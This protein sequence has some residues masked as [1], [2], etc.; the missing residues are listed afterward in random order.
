MHT[1][2]VGL[3]AGAAGLW[4]AAGTASVLGADF[5][6]VNTLPTGFGSLTQAILDANDNP[7][8]DRIVF[9]VPGS[10]V[11]TIRPPT[12]GLPAITEALEIDGFS[13]PGTRPNSL[14][15]GFDG[16]LLIQIDAAGAGTGATG[17]N[18][19]GEGFSVVRGLIIT[20][21]STG[22]LI[23]SPNNVVAGN[24][25]GVAPDGVTLVGNGSGI[26]TGR[27]SGSR[28]GGASPP[29][30]N[31]IVSGGGNVILVSSVQTNLTIVGNYLGTDATGLAPL[32]RNAVSSTLSVH[33]SYGLTLGGL[34][35]GEGN[36]I[37][38]GFYGLHLYDVVGA[39]ILGNFIG[40]GADGKTSIRSTNGVTGINAVSGTRLEGNTIACCSV[41]VAVEGTGV[42]I[43]GN[44]IYANGNFGISQTGSQPINDPGDADG[45]PNELQ[46][47]P[48]L[49]ATLLEDGV[50][51]V[52]ELSSKANTAYHLEFFAADEPGT[53]GLVQGEYFLGTQ[54][55][56]TAAD[57]RV[58]I[59][60]SY[61]T[62]RRELDWVTATAT[63]PA[64]NTSVFYGGAQARSATFPFFHSHPLGGTVSEGSN[65]TFRVSVSGATPMNFQWR[66]NGSDVPG[67]TSA[68]LTLTNVQLAQRGSYQLVARNQFGSAE[69]RPVELTVLVPPVFE[70]QP[71]SQVVVSGQWVTVSVGLR[72]FTTPPISFRWRSNGLIV[73]NSIG[74]RPDSYFSYR[75]GTNTVT[76]SVIVTN[77]LTRGAIF[78]STATNVVAADRDGD[79]LPDVYE[80]Q[81]A[82]NPDDPT[83]AAADP[84]G[85][86][87]TTGGEYSAGTDP[88]NGTSRLEWNAPEVIQG[89]TRLEFFARSN[90]TYRVEYCDGLDPGGASSAANWRTLT[91]LPAR[92]TNGP[93]ILFDRAAGSAPAR[94]Y[95]LST[96]YLP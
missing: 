3:L 37:A 56:V 26:V 17:L 76:V 19:A 28:V 58:P 7:G 41:G 44:R 46:N 63:D 1:V 94:F 33:G 15:S 4:L 73:A 65:F 85:D 18:L 9:N 66:L 21:F 27:A 14:A 30:R 55:V 60:A 91:G 34:E 61:P 39:R 57:G 50:A 20:R 92:R 35:P 40:V 6:V 10:G 43:V 88:L 24:F 47:Y 86:G 52:G 23:D 81:F 84:D 69:T 75:A 32:P 64:G 70:Y 49:T 82:L 22:I 48:T 12:S 62:P 31:V 53:N 59:L 11:R 2:R 72:E 8:P 77:P 45:G 90:R 78:S 71:V 93:A 89:F 83:D 95:R 29:D 51:L 96:P 38:T 67:A 80:A 68:T 74:T 16:T 42:T 25:I 5:E 36:V 79:G 54:E 87:V 13:Q